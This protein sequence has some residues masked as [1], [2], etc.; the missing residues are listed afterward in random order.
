MPYRCLVIDGHPDSSQYIDFLTSQGYIADIAPETLD[1]ET[2]KDYDAVIAHIASPDFGRIVDAK[3]ANPHI[4]AILSGDFSQLSVD[5]AY[6]IAQHSVIMSGPRLEEIAYTLKRL[7]SRAVRHSNV[8]APPYESPRTIVAAGLP[9][10][11]LMK[12]NKT[13]G[14]TPANIIAAHDVGESNL[15]LDQQEVSALVFERRLGDRDM[16]SYASSIKRIFHYVKT[17]FVSTDVNATDLVHNFSPHSARG[18]LDA[19]LPP[20]DADSLTETI[21]TLIA[22]RDKEITGLIE[23]GTP[24]LILLA[25][26]TGSGKTLISTRLRACLPYIQRVLSATTRE[27]RQGEKDGLDHW[28]FSDS[29]FD[30]KVAGKSM[31]EYEHRG[32]RYGV[33]IDAVDDLLEQRRDVL[34]N[35]TSPYVYDR[36]RETYGDRVL[37]ITFMPDLD[38]LRHRI[39]QRGVDPD[40]KSAMIGSAEHEHDAFNQAG[41]DLVI[42]NSSY[43]RH[44]DPA[45][46]L[47]QQ[48]DLYN[49]VTRI[50]REC[51]Y[52]RFVEDPPIF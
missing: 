1:T 9:D 18:M 32:R 41:G 29:A 50:A 31:F 51:Y 37:S 47:E 21:E 28:F 38:I 35:V 45:E 27:P 16:L 5:Q 33:D 23:R 7:D 2:C 25:G 8:H 36:L 14:D 15:A 17:L 3:Q 48:N 42:G 11:L 26:P 4:R 6:R 22:E 30:E 52:Q 12:L 34:V 49:I 43:W 13:R 44:W 24:R 40:Q 20:S 39:N 19:Y 10:D 46:R